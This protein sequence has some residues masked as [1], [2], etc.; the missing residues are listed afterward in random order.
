MIQDVCTDCLYGFTCIRIDISADLKENKLIGQGQADIR[1][2]ETPAMFIMQ[3]S[4]PYVVFS[5]HLQNI[6]KICNGICK[7]S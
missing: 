2:R 5:F 1:Q 6:H 4:Y 7:H 3:I